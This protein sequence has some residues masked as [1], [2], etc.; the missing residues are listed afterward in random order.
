MQ[1]FLGILN[2]SRDVMYA[3]KF[4]FFILEH[5]QSLKKKLAKTVFNQKIKISTHTPQ[6][7][8][9]VRYEHCICNMNITTNFTHIQS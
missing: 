3:I 5:F 6:Q 4:T 7:K 9:Y 2:W 8:S 1:T